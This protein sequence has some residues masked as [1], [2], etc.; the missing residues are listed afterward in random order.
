MTRAAVVANPLRSG[1]GRRQGPAVRDAVGAAMRARGWDEPLWL[2][3]SAD[4]PGGEMTRAAVAAR[5]DLVL[6][7]G[8]DGTVTAC[9]G[10][11]AGTGIP[12][13]VLPVGTGNL[14]ARNLRL[15]LTIGGA[16]AVALTGADR[17]VDIAMANGSPFLVM[18]GLGFDARA[19][20]SS[21]PLKERLGWAAYY[22]A[23]LGHLRDR[24]MGVVLRADARPPVSLTASEIMIGNVGSLPGG[25]ALLPAARPDDGLLDVVAVTAHGVAGWIAVGAQLLVRRGGAHLTR[26]TCRDL[27]IDLDRPQHWQRDGEPMGAA[28]ALTATVRPGQLLLRGPARG[29]AAGRRVPGPR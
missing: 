23:A 1:S 29:S 5:V 21:Q 4:N 14:L 17:P 11:L 24:P 12:L 22:L 2:E 3:T 13:A 15:P 28:G 9:A 27:R 19:L 25:L 18:A 6:A 26:L 7:S 10:A 20:R 16:L 8:G